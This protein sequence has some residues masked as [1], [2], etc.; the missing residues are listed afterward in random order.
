MS[1]QK[2][3]LVSSFALVAVCSLAF[4]VLAD[5]K[6]R[7]ARVIDKFLEA[8]GGNDQLD[9]EARV[10]AAETVNALR[11]D[12]YRRSLAITEG[13]C[14]LHPDFRTALQLL[15][16]EDVTPAIELLSKLRRSDDAFLS[17]EAD[18]YLAQS[19]TYAERFEDAI[20]IL[21]QLLDEK[22]DNM[23]Q[24]SDA[25]FLLGVSQAR[26]LDRKNAIA[27]LTKFLDETPDAPE[28]MRIGAWRQREEL[29]LLE[30][31]SMADVY[32]RMDYVRRRLQLTES[33]EKTQKQQDSIIAM[34]TKLIKVAEECECQGGGGS[35][36]SGQDGEGAD[37]NQGQGN[38]G[39][40][41]QNQNGVVRRTY[42]RGPESPWSQL[43]DR[44]R[45]PA[46]SAIK[47]KFPA[48]YEALIEQYYKSF[49]EENQ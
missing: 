12:P 5:S 27:N 3:E 16:G 8:V 2:R 9:D 48:R 7:D 32:D 33:G 1:L 38:S 22:S 29:K 43:R 24:N 26:T 6:T 23:L 30:D 17:T 25:R 41:S 39:G 49:Q 11:D 45:D 14:E 35:G 40:N 18:F 20:P 4:N 47:E 34:L 31:G 36:S 28:R 44:Q 10:R 15:G 13:L 21:Q 37:G 42:Q 46:Y 19:F